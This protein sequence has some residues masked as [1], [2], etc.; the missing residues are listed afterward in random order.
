MEC[1]LKCFIRFLT[2]LSYSILIFVIGCIFPLQLVNLSLIEI[3]EKWFPVM[4]IELIN[5]YVVKITLLFFGCIYCACVLKYLIPFPINNIFTDRYWIFFSFD[6]ISSHHIIIL[7]YVIC[8]LVMFNHHV[9]VI[10][11]FN[12]W[13]CL[14]L[15]HSNYSGCYTVCNFYSYLFFPFKLKT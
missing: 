8:V 4:D 9:I 6:M 11:L 15:F 3:H 10:S 12:K 7:L 5:S 14:R 1:T 13:T 2:W